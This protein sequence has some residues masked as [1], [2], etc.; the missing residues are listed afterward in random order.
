MFSPNTY[1]IFS[2]FC[3]SLIFILRLFARMP[4]SKI[5]GGLKIP[6]RKFVLLVLDWCVT[7][8]GNQKKGYLLDVK[9]YRS[10]EFAG[11]YFN[12]T[13]KIQIFVFDEL[14]LLD[15][16]EITI[17]EYIHHLQ[18]A[19]KKT[20]VEYSKYQNDVGYWNNPF[21]IEARR[22]SKIHKNQC[23]EDVVNSNK[24]V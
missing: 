12:H 22:L 10:K 9:Y 5:V 11:Y 4:S 19:D 21:E 2:I 14:D 17:H 18:Y 1:L 24:V 3:F 13:R 7:N 8:L 20:E 23:Y 15:L 6:K 16:T